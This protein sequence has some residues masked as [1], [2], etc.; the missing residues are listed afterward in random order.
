MSR[1]LDELVI[2]NLV[3]GKGIYGFHIRVMNVPGIAAKISQVASKRDVNIV[4]FIPSISSPEAETAII[5][6]AADFYGKVVSPTDF[7]NELK[8]TSGVIDVQ[9][10]SSRVKG[11]VVVDDRFPPD[12]QRQ[13]GHIVWI[14]Q[15][16]SAFLE[17]RK[18]FSPSA[19]DSMLY[20]SGFMVGTSS[21]QCSLQK[22][23]I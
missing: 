7:L 1:E 22:S 10:I 2:G 9:M 4:S 11:S 17:A 19:L 3:I 18:V 14:G 12:F 21:S 5:F 8:S 6:L 16:L 20:H 23:L 15:S 13:Q